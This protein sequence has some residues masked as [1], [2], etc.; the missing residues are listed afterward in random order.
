MYMTRNPGNVRRKYR[1]II[2]SSKQKQNQILKVIRAF[3][4]KVSE[5]TVTVVLLQR[6]LF[7]Q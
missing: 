2:I 7:I 5:V 6:L 1:I 4:P 3:L